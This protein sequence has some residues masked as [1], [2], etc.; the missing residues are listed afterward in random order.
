MSSVIVIEPHA[1]LRSGILQHL[2]E[3][4]PASHLKGAD[5]TAL[6][7]SFPTT[8]SGDLVLLSAALHEN[9]HML[10]DAAQR[11]FTPKRI[12]LLSDTETMPRTWTNLPALVV[13]YVPKTATPEMLVA[14]IRLVLLGGQCF[15]TPQQAIESIGRDVPTPLGPHRLSDRT[16]TAPIAPNAEAV[17]TEAEKLHIT[18]RQYEVLVL[19]G[20]GYPIK[21]ISRHLDIS[22]DTAKAHAKALYQR[23]DSH[24]RN[25]A[26][27]AAIARGATLGWLP[28]ERCLDKTHRTAHTEP[29]TEVRIRRNAM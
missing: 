8:L 20:R 14:S 29:V 10:I 7:E 24:N 19:L 26:V 5:Y 11:A 13:G 27:Y 21:T 15:Q 22:I 16:R 9:I 1:L 12:L 4:L 23:L 6:E 18:P 3:A 17:N 2:A 28:A 25:E